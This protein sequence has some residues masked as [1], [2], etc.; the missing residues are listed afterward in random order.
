MS[1]IEELPKI[2]KRGK[3]EAEKIL[4]RI[5]KNESLML[6]TNELVLPKKQDMFL[7]NVSGGGRAY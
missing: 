7:E 6:Q 4:E 3:I 1:L 2:V 5:E